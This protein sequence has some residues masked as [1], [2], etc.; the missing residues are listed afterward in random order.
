[1]DFQTYRRFYRVQD[2]IFIKSVAFTLSKLLLFFFNNPNKL[3]G[4]Q[5]LPSGSL[6]ILTT[7]FASLRVSQKVYINENV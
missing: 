3:V 5:T 2:C 6:N 4:A 7:A 1:M